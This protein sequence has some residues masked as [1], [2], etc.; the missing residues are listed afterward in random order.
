MLI[1]NFED[2]RANQP[3]RRNKISV[4][5][6]HLRAAKGLD[7]MIM[8][9]QAEDMQYFEDEQRKAQDDLEHRFIGRNLEFLNE[10]E[11]IDYARLLSLE[12]T[13]PNDAQASNG[14][15]YY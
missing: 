14:S 10:Q 13:E 15:M 11:L 8:K 6:K 2:Q 5:N 12:S 7:G 3:R 1:W 4:K 9:E